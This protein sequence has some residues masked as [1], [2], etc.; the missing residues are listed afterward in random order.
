MDHQLSTLEDV[1]SCLPGELAK[2]L[3]CNIHKKEKLVLYCESC[4]SS[5]CRDCTMMEHRS[6]KYAFAKE[7]YNKERGK[8][9]EQLSEA[10]STGLFLKQGL[11]AVS[12]MRSNVDERTRSMIKELNEIFTQCMRTINERYSFLYNQVQNIRNERLLHLDAQKSELEY[13][14]G[15]IQSSIG[16]TELTLRNSTQ[17]EVLAMKKY[18]MDRMKELTGAQY[19]CVPVADDNIR[20]TVDGTVMQHLSQLG[21]VEDTNTSPTASVVKG[22]DAPVVARQ[23]ASFLVQCY[24]GRGNPRTKGGDRVVVTVQSTDD[25]TLHIK[26]EKCFQAQVI[27][28]QNGCYSVTYTPITSGEH[29]V[30]VFINGMVVKGSPFSVHVQEHNLLLQP[31]TPNSPA[32]SHSDDASSLGDPLLHYVN[33]SQAFDIEPARPEPK[34]QREVPDAPISAKKFKLEPN[35]LD[36]LPDQLFAHSPE[37][38]RIKQEQPEVQIFSEH[39]IHEPD[40]HVTKVD[41]GVCSLPKQLASM[42][43]DHEIKLEHVHTSPAPSNS[44]F[45]SDHLEDLPSSHDFKVKFEE[46]RFLE[47]HIVAPSSSE[48]FKMHSP[49]FPADDLNTSGNP[50]IAGE[51]GG[52][53]VDAGHYP[54]D[55][56]TD[57]VVYNMDTPEPEFNHEREDHLADH[58]PSLDE[59]AGEGHDAQA[60]VSEVCEDEPPGL[61]GSSGVVS[62]TEEAPTPSRDHAENSEDTAVCSST[63]PTSRDESDT[64]VGHDAEQDKQLAE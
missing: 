44:N 2:P 45:L 7:I 55:S 38:C 42:A 43:N 53:T 63:E 32:I 48:S 29:L 23:M 52:I 5:V 8:I 30:T 56:P 41:D 51:S 34:R 12:E 19:N 17:V 36:S 57:P 50:E 20:L 9:A 26:T 62:G 27:D 1:R 31:V 35:D 54:A 37:V 10:R 61:V 13:A 18:I 58:K 3:F 49:D 28:R 24:D 59:I 4:Q 64:T 33:T 40:S 47:E 16:F 14:F 11:A 22:I 46:S 60:F 21:T 25:S 6:H 39:Y 15:S